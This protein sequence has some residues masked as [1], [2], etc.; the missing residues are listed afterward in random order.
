MHNQVEPSLFHADLL[1]EF[2]CFC[3]LSG[4]TWWTSTKHIFLEISI[5]N[6]TSQI[7]DYLRKGLFFSYI[8]SIR[9]DKALPLLFSMYQRGKWVTGLITLNIRLWNKIKLKNKLYKEQIRGWKNGSIR[10]IPL[11]DKWDLS[12]ILST[13]IPKP[14]VVVLTC[15]LSLQYDFSWA[16]VNKYLLIENGAKSTTIFLF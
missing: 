9:L 7:S 8:I 12:S 2:T 4:N 11:T 10:D 13:H 5:L 14:D 3:L 6:S 1:F 15:N 16:P